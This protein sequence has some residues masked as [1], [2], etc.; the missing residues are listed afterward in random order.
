MSGQ[1]PRYSSA[2]R[3]L[4][5]LL[6]AMA[7]S[8]L[9]RSAPAQSAATA[10]PAVGLAWSGPGPELTCLGEEGLAHAVNEYV[11]RDAFAAR[12]VELILH[13]TVERLPDRHFHALLELADTSGRVLGTRELTSGTELCSSLDEPLV[14]TVALM[15]DAPPAVEDVGA[16]PPA[17][18]APEPSSEVP[19]PPRERDRPA[20]LRLLAD[21]ALAVE[22]GLLPNVE[23]GLGLGL[24]LRAATWFSARLGGLAFWPATVRLPDD[25]SVRFA[26]AAATLELCPTL[27]SPDGARASLCVGPLYG[28]LRAKP[29]GF[30]GASDALRQ[31][32]ALSIGLRGVL[33]VQRRWVLAAGLAGVVP[34]HPDHFTYEQNGATIELFR[35]AMFA[36]VASAGVSFILF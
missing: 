28:F 4:T 20:P 16:P 19:L 26:F 29:A 9:G 12:S 21:A 1:R 24:E 14:L 36:V 35:P 11:G 27:G 7:L 3:L 32:L 10:S 31:T 22:S 25:A 5:A 23:P 6:A 2:A 17:P 15:V 18:P 33:P 34:Y 8:L 30:T 13:V